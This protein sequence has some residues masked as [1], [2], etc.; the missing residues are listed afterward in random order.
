MAKLDY[1]AVMDGAIRIRTAEIAPWML[2]LLG[3]WP[4]ISGRRVEP[5]DPSYLSAANRGV[6]CRFG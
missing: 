4:Q 1:N 6:C 3:Q 2:Q 5:A